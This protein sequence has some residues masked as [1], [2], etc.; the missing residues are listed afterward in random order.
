[1]KTRNQTGFTLIAS[2]FTLIELLVVIAII[3]ILAA[4]LF[5]VFAQAR[6]KARS[7]S[8]LSNQKQ[9]GLGLN[10]Y[11]QDYDET[12]PLQSQQQV[13]CYAAGPGGTCH[14]LTTAAWSLNWIWGI[15]PYVKNWQL[16]R[17]LTAQ[18]S[19]GVQAGTGPREPFG[20]SNN[21]YL[22][23]GAVV[24]Y[25]NQL[26]T[27][28]NIQVPANIIWVQEDGGASHR[29]FTRPRLHNVATKQYAEWLRT[30]YSFQHNQ[31]GNLLFC[32]GHAK[33]RKASSIATSDYGL[34]L[35]TAGSSVGPNDDGAAL[36]TID[37]KLISD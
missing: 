25:P 17:C 27:L 13:N 32:D 14:G 12:M 6:D 19:T 15:S 23:N 5:P 9:I 36:A 29:A 10:Q 31:G 20:N 34:G 37:S 35:S 8:C 3:A 7:A 18:D 16:Y 1:M 4:I 21:S 11:I 28:A 33:W 22:V 2:A 24:T 30:G 26:R